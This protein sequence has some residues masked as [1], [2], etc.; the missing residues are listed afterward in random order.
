MIYPH[1]YIYQAVILEM[2]QT[3]EILQILIERE[4]GEVGEYRKCEIY[5][6]VIRN[7]I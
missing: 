3:D 1:P 5:E 4:P 6:K 7:K 2:E